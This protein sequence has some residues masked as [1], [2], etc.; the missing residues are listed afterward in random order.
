MQR[1]ALVTVNCGHVYHYQC[2]AFWLKGALKK[3]GDC[4]CA[5]CRT[6]VRRVTKLWA[7][8][9]ASKNLDHEFDELVIALEKKCFEKDYSTLLV[10]FFGKVHVYLSRVDSNFGK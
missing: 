3:G 2:A 5:I 6:T 10:S 7:F 1:E 8:G 9:D 4:A